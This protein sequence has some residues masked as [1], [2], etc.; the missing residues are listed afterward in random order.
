MGR[1]PQMEI[2]AA[3]LQRRIKKL[4]DHVHR[5]MRPHQLSNPLLS[6]REAS[7]RPTAFT[8]Q[9]SMASAYRSKTVEKGS[10]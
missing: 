5:Q 2:Q 6:Q 1:D 8:H 7:R 4:Q 10:S 9:L 3:Q